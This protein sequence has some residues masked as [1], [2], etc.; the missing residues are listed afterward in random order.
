MR[1][2]F[3]HFSV[4]SLKHLCVEAKLIAK[5]LTDQA[6]VVARLCRDDIDT[7]SIKTMLGK[8]RFCCIQ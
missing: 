7:C 8:D 1:L 2:E 4:N 6:F 3:S 5:V